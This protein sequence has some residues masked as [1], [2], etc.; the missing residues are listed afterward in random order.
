[1]SFKDLPLATSSCKKFI[2][3]KHTMAHFFVMPEV[4]E[5]T[6]SSRLYQNQFSFPMLN[7][8]RA[9][10]NSSQACISMQYNL[11]KSLTHSSSYC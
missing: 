3:M 11:F 7:S 1:M 10:N 4:K 5:Q 6:A 9:Q 8:S 2:S